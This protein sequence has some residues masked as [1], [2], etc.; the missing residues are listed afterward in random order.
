MSRS[1]LRSPSLLFSGKESLPSTYDISLPA[2]LRGEAVRSA[3]KSDRGVCFDFTSRSSSVKNVGVVKVSGKGTAEFLNNK[4]SNTY[5]SKL[6][7]KIDRYGPNGLEVKIE[8]GIA[9]EGGLLN[10][11]GHIIDRLNLCTFPSSDGIGIEAYMM[12]SPGHAGSQ[13]FNRLDPFI[14]PLDEVKLIDMCPTK[15]GQTSGR[16]QVFTF[17]ATKVETAQ[18]CIKESVLPI[19]DEWHLDS[20]FSFPTDSNDCVRYSLSKDDNVSVEL[21]ICKDVMLP[22]CV[23]RGYTVVISDKAQYDNDVG[24]QVWALATAESNFNGPVALGPL[25]YETLRIEGKWVKGVES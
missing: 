20:F 2:G 13:L 18:N 6:D 12:T 1:I 16:S 17:A 7:E 21:L 10:S 25:E 14:F 9:K 24:S 15:I 19:F 3:L 23:S 4:L 8:R 5:P 11:K 22:S